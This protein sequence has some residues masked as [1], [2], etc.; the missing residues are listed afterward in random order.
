VT[1]RRANEFKIQWA[2]IYL[3]NQQ[4]EAAELYAAD[5]DRVIDLWGDLLVAG[6]TISFAFNEQTDSFICT[7]MGKRSGDANE[8]WGMTSHAATIKKALNRALYK[9]FVA[10]A[11]S[12]WGEVAERYSQPQP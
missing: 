10:C 12:S 2:N 4:K 7:L 5:P 6:Y 9:H 11:G 8:G 3:D 1:D